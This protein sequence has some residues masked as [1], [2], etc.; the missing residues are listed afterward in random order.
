MRSYFD[1]VDAQHKPRPPEPIKL[2]LPA[3]GD[4][5]P[6]PACRGHYAPTSRSWP[7][8]DRPAAVVMVCTGCGWEARS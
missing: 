7:D 4:P 5:C 2:E 6:V 1:R 3:A 8:P